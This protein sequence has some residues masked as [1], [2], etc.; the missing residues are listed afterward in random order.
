MEEIKHTYPA[1][2][3]HFLREISAKED[4]LQATAKRMDHLARAFRREELHHLSA[5]YDKQREH[6]KRIHEKIQAEL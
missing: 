3:D 1:V 4:R 5:D 2:W 6:D